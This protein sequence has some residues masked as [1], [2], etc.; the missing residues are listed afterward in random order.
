MKLQEII[1]NEF[2]TDICIDCIEEEKMV[3]HLCETAGSLEDD[4]VFWKLLHDVE[5]RYFEQGFIRGISAVKGGA[6]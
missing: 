3:D 6:V 4:E 1:D 5:K 2:N